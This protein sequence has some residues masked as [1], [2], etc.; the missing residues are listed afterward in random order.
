MVIRLTFVFFAFLAFCFQSALAQTFIRE[1]LS[2][3]LQD[4]NKVRSLVVGVATMKERNNAPRDSAEY[5]TSWEYWSAIH[6]YP[7]PGPRS[8]SIADVKQFFENEF[9]ETA[10]FYASFYEGIQDI[11]P[12]DALAED[13]WATCRHGSFEQPD[14]HFLSWHRMYLYYFERVL[15]AASGDAN[16]ALPYWD[17][18]ELGTA[19]DEP[20][21]MPGLFATPVLGQQGNTFQNPLHEPRRTPGFGSFTQLDAAATGIDATLALSDFFDFQAGIELGVHGYIHCAVGNACLAPMIGIVPLAGNDPIFWHHHAN[22]DRMWSC[23]LEQHG[24][25]ELPTDQSWLDTRFPFVDENGDRVEMVVGDLF[26]PNSPID[27]VYDDVSAAGCF[28]TPPPILVAGGTEL[29]GD[30]PE[31]M[32]SEGP[33]SHVIAEKITLSDTTAIV[34][35][36]LSK[37][38][39]ASSEAIEALAQSDVTSSRAIL[40][41]RGV[42]VES[43][44]GASIAVELVS[45]TSGERRRVGTLAFF[46]V[47]DRSHQHTN[48]AG[49]ESADGFAFDV[50]DALGELGAAGLGGVS[51]EL[52]G[53]SLVEPQAALD[54]A[55]EFVRGTEQDVAEDASALLRALENAP[56]DLSAWFDEES[57][58][59]AALE[60]DD[61]TATAEDEA[62]AQER[63]RRAKFKV[64]EISLTFSGL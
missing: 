62:A 20:W 27:Y 3:F 15:R 35:L 52:C 4:P 11:T 34:P 43:Q 53:E 44:P 17:Y 49:S 13:V 10:P 39:R 45:S 56:E 9:P 46:A 29:P 63:L 41:L 40:R 25:S 2:A 38:E 12:P 32:D 50:T 48:M 24:E 7:G 42:T 57:V 18:T 21:R 14:P 6:G 19:P 59:A 33:M 22:I 64:D 36:A 23:W 54:A 47:G 1:S 51:L 55:A 37:D 5:R 8:A 26:G 16:F 61:V 58:A 31:M 28:R 30:S 60:F